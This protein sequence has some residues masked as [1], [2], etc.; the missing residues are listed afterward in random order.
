MCV[1]GGLLFC[2]SVYLQMF[3]FVCVGVVFHYR[4]ASGRYAFS[5]PE[6]QNACDSIGA[7]IAT[8]DQLLA[9]YH[10]GY[11]QCDAGWL[12]DQSVRYVLS[13]PKKCFVVCSAR[14]HLS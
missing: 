1:W 8:P 14:P 13:F 10:D 9:A 2:L 3:L 6:A 5:F 12:A 4:H 11:E 7:Q